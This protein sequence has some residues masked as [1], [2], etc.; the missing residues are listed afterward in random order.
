M[1]RVR[2]SPLAEVA[3]YFLAMT[4]LGALGLQLAATVTANVIVLSLPHLLDKNSPR[5]S[6]VE[7]RR[8]DAAQAVSPMP[9]GFGKL[10]IALEAS[11]VPYDVLA[12]QLDLADAQQPLLERRP[13]FPSQLP[14]AAPLPRLQP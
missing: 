1:P 7:Q 5:P 4:C 13:L 9:G 12:A 6:R 8:I 3:A 11:S 10:V 14:S 2:V